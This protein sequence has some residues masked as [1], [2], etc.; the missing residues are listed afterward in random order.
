MFIKFVVDYP[1]TITSEKLQWEYW[2][3]AEMS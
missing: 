1:L 2:Q 3:D